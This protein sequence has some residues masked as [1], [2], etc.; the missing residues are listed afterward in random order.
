MKEMNEPCEWDRT[1]NQGFSSE[2][3]CFVCALGIT[4]ELRDSCPFEDM[5]RKADEA[6]KRLNLYR[7]G[8]GHELAGVREYRATGEPAN[9]DGIEIAKLINKV[10]K[11]T[12][13]ANAV[14]KYKVANRTAGGDRP[15]AYREVL[16]ALHEFEGGRRPE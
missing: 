13:L 15:G 2:H 7:E 4:R 16:D 14:H 12:R 6:V 8:V 9:S 3:T 11:A 5:K 10:V 1:V